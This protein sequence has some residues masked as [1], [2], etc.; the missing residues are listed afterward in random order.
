[1][2]TKA[3]A[4]APHRD[5]SGY[6]STPHGRF[7][8]VTTILSGGIPKPALVHWS[9]AEVARAALDNLP[10]LVQARGR[11]ARAECF[12]WLR[13]ASETKRD[14][15]AALGSAVHRAV[16]A[17]V[18]GAPR[19]EPGP[20]EQAVLAG[21]FRFVEDWRPVWEATELVLANPADGWA[22]TGDAWAHLPALDA[23]VVIDWKSGKGVYDEAA[24]QLSAYQ[25]ATVGWLRDG[26]EVTPPAA[27]RA[28][29]VHLRPDA[30]PETGYA[31]LPVDTSDQT[32]QQFLDASRVA[33]RRTGLIGQPLPLAA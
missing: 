26:T 18:L 8:S 17:E 10:R 19:P 16:E 1:M 14:R 33:Q 31:V 4:A 2:T 9:A 24:L 22:G 20:D 21:F 23:L 12:E 15:G 13:R 6:Y 11:S 30:Y 28:V 3:L 25:R 27:S 32:Y 29:V 7:M 5:R